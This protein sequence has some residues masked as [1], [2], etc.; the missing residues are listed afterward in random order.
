MTL[1]TPRT[2]LSALILVALAACGGAKEVP[3]AATKSVT[4][5]SCKIMVS[6]KAEEFKGTANGDDQAKVEEAAWA[7]VCAKLP[8]ADR[9]S[10][11]DESKFS[12]SKSGGSANAGGATSYNTNITLS[13]KHPTLDGSADSEVSKDEACKAALTRACE[14]AGEKGDCLAGGKFE[15]KGESSSST[16]S[17]TSE[18]GPS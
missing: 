16:T 18:A 17:K 1:R 11:K 4:K 15:K 9:P 6:K 10:C 2:H 8:E 14:A 7:D 13:A 12:V 5:H 3:A